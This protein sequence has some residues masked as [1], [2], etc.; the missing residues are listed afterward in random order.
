M[1]PLNA[2][3]LRAGPT[4]TALL[5]GVGLEWALA[6]MLLALLLISTLEEVALGPPIRLLWL[7]G[8]A[9]LTFLNVGAAAA[10]Y[11]GAALVLSVHHFDGQGSWAQRPDNFAL[12]LLVFYLVWVRAFDR[13]ARPLGGAGI[14]VA[15]LVTFGLLQVLLRVGFSTYELS[16]FMRMFGVPLG[17]FILLWRAGLT[18]QELRAFLLVVACVGVYLA[19]VSLLEALGWYTLVVPP[20]LVDPIARNLGSPRVGGLAMQPEWNALE[21]S[22][23]FCVI[24]LL[25]RVDPRHGPAKLGWLVGGALCF[26]AIYFTYTRAAW[27][28][29]LLAGV[30]LFWSVSAARGMAVSRRILFLTFAVGFAAMVLFAPS[31]MLKARVEDT[32]NVYFRLNLWAAGLSVI[33]ENPLVGVGYGQFSS[34]VGPYIRERSWI[35][36]TQGLDVGNMAHNT[37]LSTA[38]EFG[39]VGLVLYVLALLGAYRVTRAA[40]GNAWGGTGRCWVAGYTIVYLVNVQFITAHELGANLLYFCVMGAIAGMRESNG[41][42]APSRVQLD[43]STLRGAA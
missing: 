6:V 15:L 35:P 38:A 20:W 23:T 26:L 22:L 30:P 9:F 24:L 37:F 2:A 41:R 10:L 29:L 40:A 8:F 19:A 31:A 12:L 17:L 32:G 36:A 39:L 7:A 33:A 3:S 14:A 4:S 5:R 18:R 13:A 43:R 34:H 11:I 16:W 28:G 42:G 1:P 21:L 27:L 25:R